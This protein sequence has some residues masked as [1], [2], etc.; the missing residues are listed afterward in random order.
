MIGNLLLGNRSSRLHSSDARIPTFAHK[1]YDACDGKSVSITILPLWRPLVYPR[2]A[3][4]SELATVSLR[5]ER[6]PAEDR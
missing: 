6:S 5:P 3:A 4:G 1:I 2:S